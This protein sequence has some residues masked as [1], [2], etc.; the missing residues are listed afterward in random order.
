MTTMQRWIA[1]GAAALVTAA[2]ALMA[3]APA[4][5]PTPPAPPHFDTIIRDG[6]CTIPKAASPAGIW[7]DVASTNEDVLHDALDALIRTLTDVRDSLA[8]GEA[9]DAVFTSACRW[10]DALERTQGR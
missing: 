1:L 7:K 10:R 6:V 8:T 3:P 2:C 4:P 9:I 5:A